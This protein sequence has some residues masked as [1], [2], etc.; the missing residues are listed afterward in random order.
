VTKEKLNLFEFASGLQIGKESTV[1][2]PPAPNP[3]V[4]A[5]KDKA[6]EQVDEAVKQKK[7]AE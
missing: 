2:V 4:P 3:V 5:T 7:R 1:P 6:N